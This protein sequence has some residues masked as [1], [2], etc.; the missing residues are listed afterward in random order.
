MKDRDFQSSVSQSTSSEGAAAARAPSAAGPTVSDSDPQATMGGFSSGPD[1][2]TAID[3]LSPPSKKSSNYVS[4]ASHSVLLFGTVIA[5]R[6]EILKLLGQGGMGAVYKARDRAVERTVAL[7][8]IRP[9]YAGNPA[10]IDRFKQEL[11]LSTQVTHKNVVRIFDLGEADGLKFITMEYIEGKDLHTLMAERKS[12]PIEESV[13]IMRQVCRALE[14]AHA[15]GVI[16]RDL[17][18]QNIMRDETG[19]VVVMDF[20]L[21]RSLDSRDGMTQSGAVIGTLEYMSPEQGL[22]KNLDRRSDLFTVGLIFYELLTGKMPYKADS[23]LASLLKRT[24][25]AAVPV[26]QIDSSI[27]RALSNL[28]AKCLESDVAKR[29]QNVGEILTDLEAWHG[30]DAAA[31]LRFPGIKPWGQTIRWSWIAVI[32]AVLIVAGL[33]LF[34]TR[35][36]LGSSSAQHPPVTLLVSDFKNETSDAVFDGTLE[37]TFNLALESASFIN[38]FSRSQAHSVGA[39]LQPGTSEL[40]ESLARLVA[41]R[42]GIGVI[43]SGSVSRAGTGYKISS[44]AVDAVTGKTIAQSESEATNKEDVL[45]LV[46]KLAADIR[47]ALG[48]TTPDSVQLAKAET[49]SSGSLEAAHEYAVGQSLQDAG[50]FKDAVAH[51]DRALQLDPDMGRA[52]AGLATAN[53]AMGQ[54]EKALSN[55]QSAMARIDRMTDR[56]KYRTRG[57]YYLLMLDPLKAIEEYTALVKQFPADDA[58]YSNLA[59]AYSYRRDMSKALEEG[60]HAVAVSPKGVIERINVSLYATYSGDFAAGAKA[61]N[62]VLG[63]DPN[64]SYAYRALALAQLG[65]ENPAAAAQT[66]SKLNDLGSDGASIASLGRADLALYQGNATDAIPQL[67]KGIEADIAAKNSTGAGLKLVALASAQ[68]MT[69]QTSQ[70][71]ATANKAAAL[72][73]D[74]GVQVT[75]GRVLVEAGQL[76]R[77]LAIAAEL[78]ASIEPERQIHGKLLRGEAKLKS[79]EIQQAIALFEAAQAISD[80][81]LG[82]LDLGR[83]YLERGSFPEAYSEFE[84]C[85]KRRGETGALFLDDLPTFRFLPQ[86]YYYLGRAQEGLK[87]PAAKES[88]QKFVSIQEKGT[89]PL[90]ADARI[91]LAR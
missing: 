35:S 4:E 42:E 45:R 86:A 89:G 47:A 21:A 19:R 46:G 58:G 23:A 43:V 9:E 25:E 59:L 44:R 81:W 65:A 12:F 57:G 71:I 34:Y 53:A 7:K 63:S 13:E 51:Y 31:S 49:F 39:T 33:G 55:Y 82:R 88:Y 72:D 79:G 61:A 62:E 11:V 76:P 90:L 56:E 6:Y 85:I 83:A 24:Q 20:G 41:V 29:Y 37:P 54:R 1:T 28:V 14:A 15:V 60:R 74:L 50:K 87:S 68:L 78:S 16:H 70:A 3:G 40:N 38:S 8:V 67:E 10:V 18:P 52:Y 84:I 22:G 73:K 2:P 75:A 48:D 80:T 17:K 66:Y 77:A 69:G 5:E 64:T 26:S 36:H 30:K 91:R 27:P 32:A